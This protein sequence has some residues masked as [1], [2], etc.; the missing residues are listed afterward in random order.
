MLEIIGKILLKLDILAPSMHLNI[1]GGWEIRSW[2]GV[3]ISMTYLAL[4]AYYTASQVID[5]LDT[6]KPFIAVQLQLNIQYPSIDL[7]KNKY[8]L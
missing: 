1:N 3:F 8:V 2:T 5:Y 7:V 6:T 4:A